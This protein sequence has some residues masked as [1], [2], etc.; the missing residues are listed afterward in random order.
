MDG[1]IYAY[2][3]FHKSITTSKW[4]NLSVWLH[5]SCKA[6]IQILMIAGVP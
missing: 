6:C 3:I 2:L 5:S 1:D 4:F